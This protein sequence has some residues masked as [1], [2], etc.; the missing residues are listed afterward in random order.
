MISLLVG[1]LAVTGAQACGITPCQNTGG[2]QAYVQSGAASYASGASTNTQANNWGNVQ[3]QTTAHGFNLGT[4][5][6]YGGSAVDPHYSEVGG[7]AFIQGAWSVP[8]Q[9]H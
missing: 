5:A 4:G 7:Q 9:R 3:Y 2:F 8:G 1:M 6:S